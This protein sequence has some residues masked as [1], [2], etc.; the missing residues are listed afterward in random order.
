MIKL[1]NEGDTRD[2][3]SSSQNHGTPDP[4]GIRTR[5]T[6][7]RIRPRRLG[8]R[9]SAQAEQSPSPPPEG[10]RIGFVVGPVASAASIA[11]NRGR[12]PLCRSRVLPVSLSVPAF[13]P[14][15][16]S[17]PLFPVCPVFFHL[18]LSTFSLSSKHSSHQSLGAFVSDCHSFLFFFVNIFVFWLLFFFFFWSELLTSSLIFKSWPISLF[19]LSRRFYFHIV[20]F[21]I[22][23]SSDCQ[24]RSICPF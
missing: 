13:C 1:W 2:A 7:T 15:K 23:Q 12:H 10:S 21:F 16:L 22:S 24:F 14:V 6:R 19:F 11:H 20:S 4:S 5:R 18:V 9:D 3:A 8:S 17:T